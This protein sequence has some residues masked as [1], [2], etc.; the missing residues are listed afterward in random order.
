MNLPEPKIAIGMEEA[1]KFFNTQWKYIP[2]AFHLDMDLKT[3]EQRIMPICRKEEIG[4]GGQ[5][6]VV[7]T[8]V[9]A[10]YVAQDLRDSVP[11]DE[12]SS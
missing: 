5:A 7:R 2:F 4:R 1:E 11:K 10:D 3:P 12:H 6:R 9:Q 8:A